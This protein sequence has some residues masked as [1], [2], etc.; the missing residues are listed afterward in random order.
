M[1][2]KERR[3]F[4]GGRRDEKATSCSDSDLFFAFSALG[5]PEDQQDS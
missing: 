3:T 1:D 5:L 4:Q 2:D